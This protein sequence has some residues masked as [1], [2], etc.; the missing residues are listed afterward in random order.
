MSAGQLA[1][2]LD[3]YR[4][5]KPADILRAV[6]AAAELRRLEASEAALLAALKSAH[7]RCTSKEFDRCKA[8]IEATEEARRG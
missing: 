1:E 7:A 4:F 6:Q 3:S 8:L 5:R 2:W